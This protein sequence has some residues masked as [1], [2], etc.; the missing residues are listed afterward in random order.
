MHWKQNL[1]QKVSN[2]IWNYVDILKRLLRHMLFQSVI[3]HVYLWVYDINWFF[4]PWSQVCR[5]HPLLEH[6]PDAI[7]V[8]WKWNKLKW[9]SFYI[10]DNIIWY[11]KVVQKWVQG[12][13]HFQWWNEG[14]VDSGTHSLSKRTYHVC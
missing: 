6:V 10:T 14:L 13:K 7:L 2:V 1:K 11:K 12:N 3:S 9:C 5:C 4:K 8:L